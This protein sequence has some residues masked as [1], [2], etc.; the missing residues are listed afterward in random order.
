MEDFVITHSRSSSLAVQEVK[1]VLDG[2]G[3]SVCSWGAES[4]DLGT[5]GGEEAGTWGG[6]DDGCMGGG[7]DAAE[8]IINKLLKDS[9]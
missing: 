5:R 3:Q 7:E 6:G 8:E 2:D 4:R 1:E 9:L